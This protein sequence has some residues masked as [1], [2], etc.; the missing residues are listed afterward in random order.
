MGPQELRIKRARAT[1]DLDLT[2]SETL[3][4][5]EERSLNNAIREA[6]Q[7]AAD[8]D[9]SNFFVF[10]VGTIMQDLDGAPYGGARLPMDGRTFVRFHID[11]GVGDMVLMPLEMTQG[12][13]WL[14]FAGIPGSK[15]PTIS[16]E[17]Q[18]AEKVHAYT[19]PPDRPNTRVRD[20]VDIVLLIRGGKMNP[21]EVRRALKA[22]FDRRKTHDLPEALKRP[23][24]SWKERYRSMASECGISEEMT[25][26]FDS[27]SGYISTVNS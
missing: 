10:T 16:K 27:L 4:T 17:Q 20:I 7:R 19:L 2:L 11:V 12:R 25:D 24:E 3:G 14:D 13:K 8:I 21:T 23:P 1:K 26:A 18:F 15:Y 6:L 22:T 5:T 9:L